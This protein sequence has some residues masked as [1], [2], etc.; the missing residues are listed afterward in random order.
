VRKQID[1]WGEEKTNGRIQNILKKPL[2]PETHLL[3]ANAIFFKGNWIRQFDEAKTESMPFHR[4]DNESIE[5]PMMFQ[6]GRFPFTWTESAQILQLP[7]E[8]GDLSMTIVLPEDPRGLPAIEERMTSADIA[9]WQEELF[10]E[11]VY[12][13]LPRFKMTS[14]FDLIK[15]GSLRNLGIVRALDQSKAEFPGI[16][17]YANW[18]SIQI[19]VHKAFVEVNEQGTEAA[20]VAVGGCFPA[21]TPVPTPNGIV[22]IEAIEPESAVY[23]F[24]LSKG[25]WVTTR[26]AQRRPWPFSGQMVTIQAGSETIEATWNHPFLVARGADLEARRVP[27]DLP[28]GEEVATVHGRWVEA[29]D[30]REGDVLLARSSSNSTVTGTSTRNMTG[31]VYVLEIDGFHNH[32]VGLRGILVHNAS[33]G[34]KSAGPPSFRADHPFLFFIRDEPTGSILFMGR[35]TDPIG[36]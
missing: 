35:V 12:V 10:E 18:L 9:S 32:A 27:V 26:V 1:A 24:D 22:P 16:G 30:I 11:D 17:P 25:K 29:R 33:G 7:Y 34:K 36:E 14:E 19:F 8:G 20:A 6:L 31:E 28:P 2:D 4:L 3:L 15:D 23:A 5:V 21:G 13:Y